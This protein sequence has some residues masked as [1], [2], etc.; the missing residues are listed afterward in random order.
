MIAETTNGIFWGR[1]TIGN[2]IP[3]TIL[4]DEKMHKVLLEKKDFMFVFNEN[5]KSIAFKNL[6]TIR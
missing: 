1:E 5:R 2:G 6:S 3:L 4:Q